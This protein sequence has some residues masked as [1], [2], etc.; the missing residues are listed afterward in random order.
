MRSLSQ[1]WVAA[2]ELYGEA[3]PRVNSDRLEAM[4]DLIDRLYKRLRK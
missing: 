3:L 2:A 4:P 1:A